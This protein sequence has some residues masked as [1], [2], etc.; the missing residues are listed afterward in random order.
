MKQQCQVSCSY[1]KMQCIKLTP[2]TISQSIHKNSNR[3]LS[4]YYHSHPQQTNNRKLPL[5]YHSRP[6]KLTV[7]GGAL[8]GLISK[9]KRLVQF[10]VID[11]LV[12]RHLSLDILKWIMSCIFQNTCENVS[13]YKDNSEQFEQVVLGKCVPMWLYPSSTKAT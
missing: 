11:I 6:I 5:Y 1:Y 7:L 8:K 12:N 2:S 9:K 3:K 13:I 10:I 4:L